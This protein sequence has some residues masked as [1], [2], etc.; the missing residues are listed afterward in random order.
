MT[1]KLGTVEV[2]TIGG[3]DLSYCTTTSTWERNP[4]ILDRTGYGKTSKVKRGGLGDG[5][6]TVGGWYDS[7]V[8]GP[9]AVLEPLEGTNVELV[10]RPEGTGS[11]LPQRTVDVVV[12]K[13]AETAPVDGLV[14]W[15]CDFAM[16]D[17]VDFTAQAA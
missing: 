8:T 6:F 10:H 13:Y 3:D 12:G 1:E 5:T 2:W 17:E 14:T 9:R 7:G 15:T 11:A 16:S 4:D